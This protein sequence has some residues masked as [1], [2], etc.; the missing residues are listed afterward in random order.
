[1]AASTTVISRDEIDS[2]KASTVSEVLR[3]AAGVDIISTGSLGDDNDIRLRGADRDQVLVLIDGVAINN[4]L[5]HRAQFLGSIPLD[6][7]E[8]IEIVRG[9]QGVLYGSDAVGGVINIITRK[10]SETP[11][12]SAT[13]E[14]GN[15]ET[16]R[17]I[18]TGAMQTEK[19][20][21]SGSGSRTDQGGRFPRDRFGETA[22]SVNAGY[23]FL[24]ELKLSGGANYFRTD[25][26][27]FYEF[28]SGFDPATG[29]VLVKIDPDNDNRLHR[30][31][32]VANLSLKS[33]P[34]SWWSSELLYGLLV[35][36]ETLKNS[37]VGETADPGF[38][39]V[40]QDFDGTGFE[41][42]VDLRNFFSIYESPKF[43]TQATVGFEFQD[44]RLHFTDFGGFE[45]PGPGQEG[46]RQNYAPYFQEN[47]RFFDE[48]LILTG[49]TRFDHNT[50]FGD[51]WSPAGSVLFKIPK[52]KTTFRASYGE[53]FHAPTINEFFNQILL[54]ITG[55]PSFQAARLQAELSQSY[56]AGIEQSFGAADGNGI[57]ANV[58]ATFFY[59]DYDRL[60]DGLQF[61]ND[62]YS[63]GVEL[64]ASVTP[65]RWLKVGG[66]YTFLKAINETTNT[67]LADRPRHHVNVFV[68]SDPTD[69]LTVRAD[70][71]VVTDRA[72]PSAISTSAGDLNVLFIDP[73]GNTSA[74]GTIPGY[75]KVDLS[76]SYEILRDKLAMKSGR[77]YFKIENLLDDSYQ[78]KFG[79][80]APGI[81]FLAGAKATF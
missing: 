73:A 59:I 50:T 58:T 36:L 10:G 68:Q 15:L 31:N 26:E 18:V 40:D 71:N 69:R 16:F 49:G 27:L 66:N 75:V 42:T 9:S 29:T 30:D 56:E 61:M 11:T 52:T 72:V 53:G 47:F 22:F 41:N 23:Q 37:S 62:A 17:E 19:F 12:V 70:V 7:V 54:Q 55:D 64:G 4:V 46:D 3:N 63:T 35:D 67:R 45:F 25:Q 14:G 28:Q 81:T 5:E 20:Q 80:P 78:E 74:S 43:S 24:P 48:K 8:R 21:F 38:F 76:S 13:F 32:V 77:L 44:E 33:Q 57:S 34:F 60:F 1:M 39:P 2:Q 65:W 6:N 51:E 79:F